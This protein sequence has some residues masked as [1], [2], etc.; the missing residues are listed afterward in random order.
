MRIPSTATPIHPHSIYV[1]EANCP[2]Q[3]QYSPASEAYH[4]SPQP[5]PLAETHGATV[6]LLF[7]GHVGVLRVIEP[8]HDVVENHDLAVWRP[9]IDVVDVYR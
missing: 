6:R 5:S 7:L 3:S 4:E 1:A 9:Q 8:V 2:C